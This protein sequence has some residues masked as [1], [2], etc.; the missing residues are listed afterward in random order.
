MRFRHRMRGNGG[1]ILVRPGIAATMASDRMMTERRGS[2]FI[3]LRV[4]PKEFIDA[5]R[6]MSFVPVRVVGRAV[7]RRIV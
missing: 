7:Q 6:L 5:G 2:R 4:E 1:S 3:E